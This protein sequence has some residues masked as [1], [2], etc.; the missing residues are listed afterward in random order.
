VRVPADRLMVDPALDVG[1]WNHLLVEA[2]G[3]SLRVVL[4][5]VQTVAI[6]DAP[7]T[8]APLALRVE[9]DAPSAAF[10]ALELRKP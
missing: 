5:G 9:A 2:R 8:P 1:G 6:D 3:K 10:R 7:V 4:N